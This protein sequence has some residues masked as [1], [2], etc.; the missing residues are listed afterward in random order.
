MKKKTHKIHLSTLN[1]HSARRKAILY[2]TA[3]IRGLSNSK[4]DDCLS[5]V[6]STLTHESAVKKLQVM[7]EF[8]GSP[9]PIN[10]G[11]QVFDA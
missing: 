9:C 10:S 1:V 4:V 11:R 8:F 7:S 6:M 2:F 5:L 3:F